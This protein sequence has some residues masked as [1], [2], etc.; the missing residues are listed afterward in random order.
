M[1]VDPAKHL[2]DPLVGVYGLDEPLIANGK[3]LNGGAAVGQDV[4]HYMGPPEKSQ[5][6]CAAMDFLF[7]RRP[8]LTSQIKKSLVN[9]LRG[10]TWNQ[11]PMII[12]LG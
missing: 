11:I 2:L 5:I 1:P 6:I 4:L 3:P 12:E 10:L 9:L 8:Q 7:L